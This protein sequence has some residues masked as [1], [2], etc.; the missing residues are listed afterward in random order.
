M[1]E[2]MGKDFLDVA[3]TGEITSGI[4]IERYESCCGPYKGNAIYHGGLAREP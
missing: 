1:T 4:G 3:V 2:L